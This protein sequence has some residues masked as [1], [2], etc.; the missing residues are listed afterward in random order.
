MSALGLTG[1]VT[2]ALG[3]DGGPAEVAEHH[4][5]ADPALVLDLARAVL[6][7]GSR[8]SRPPAGGWIAARRCAPARGSSGRSCSTT[9]PRA[10]RRDLELLEVL[11]KQIGTGLDNVRLYGELR[12]SAGRVEMLRRIT[13][14][15]PR[16]ASCRRS[17]PPSPRS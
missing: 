11:G 5:A 2:F 10:P 1:G 8:S 17:S 12:A 13:A 9:A 14:R 7:H 15:S 6:Q 4:L 3:A 16:A